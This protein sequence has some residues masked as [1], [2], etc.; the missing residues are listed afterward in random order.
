M[1]AL[2]RMEKANAS[3]PQTERQET[4]KRPPHGQKPTETQPWGKDQIEKVAFS[5]F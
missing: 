4:E 2:A 3:R 5:L 1:W